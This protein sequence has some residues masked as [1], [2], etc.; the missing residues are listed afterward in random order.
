[1]KKVL[2][3]IAAALVLS[4][5]GPSAKLVKQA[6]PMMREYFLDKMS[7]PETY[8]PLS[9]EY[10]GRGMVDKRHY[11]FGL[12]GPTGDSTIV[13]VFLHTFSHYNRSLD[14]IEDD[15]TVYFTDDMK[16]VLTWHVGTPKEGSIKWIRE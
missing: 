6:E 14:K 15:R 7:H 11:M 4:C 13:R 10:L 1:M 16:L 3:L 5:G 9:T 2:V 8:E 12:E